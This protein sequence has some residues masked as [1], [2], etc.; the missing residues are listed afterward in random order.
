[1]EK[2]ISGQ[3]IRQLLAEGGAWE[4]MVPAAVARFLH[5][6]GRW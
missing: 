3:Q 5:G 6:R 2:N 1:L 4:R